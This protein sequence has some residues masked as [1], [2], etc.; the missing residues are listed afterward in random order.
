MNIKIKPKCSTLTISYTKRVGDYFLAFKI[1]SIFRLKDDGAIL[2]QTSQE[3]LFTS[4]RVC[5]RSPKC[6]QASFY[7]PFDDYTFG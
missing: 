2:V 4:V 1:V 6:Y 5:H 3:T 7:S